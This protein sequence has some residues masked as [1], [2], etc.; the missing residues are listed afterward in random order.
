MAEEKTHTLKCSPITVKK[1]ANIFACHYALQPW[2]MELIHSSKD[3]IG[4]FKWLEQ[5]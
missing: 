5:L 3:S 4:L 2:N 1:M